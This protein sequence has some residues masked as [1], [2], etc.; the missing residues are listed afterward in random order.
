MF[1]RQGKID[2]EDFFSF[3]EQATAARI[4]ED[5]T[6]G[7]ETRQQELRRLCA[8]C[9]EAVV[10]Y[11]IAIGLDAP[12]LDA[13]YAR[14][15]AAAVKARLAEEIRRPTWAVSYT[16]AIRSI[17]SVLAIYLQLYED[18]RSRTRTMIELVELSARTNLAS[19]KEK[20]ADARAE[21]YAKHVTLLRR[22]VD[23]QAKW[24]AKGNGSV[25]DS[26]LAHAALAGME[27]HQNVLHQ[28]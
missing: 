15:Y 3:L 5:K 8:L 21:V 24:A 13:H 7:L 14:A 19:A 2:V 16:K 12:P 1:S 27:A 22:I 10:H 25:F 17:N 9:D 18:G 4:A 6:R 23:Q 11:K 20:R 28:P 26:N